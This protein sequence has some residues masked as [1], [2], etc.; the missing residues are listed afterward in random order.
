MALNPYSQRLNKIYHF[1]VFWQP[2]ATNRMDLL[3]K[4]VASVAS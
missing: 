1:D 4:F 3:E 2:L